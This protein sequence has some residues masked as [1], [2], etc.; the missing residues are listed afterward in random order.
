MNS[1]TKMNQLKFGLK[2]CGLTPAL[3]FLTLGSACQ[4]KTTVTVTGSDR[5]TFVLAGSGNLSEVIISKPGEEQTPNPL[6]RENTLWRISAVNMPGQPVE[7]LHS[8]T[9]GVVPPGYRQQ[10]PDE[11]AP[12]QLQANKRYGFLFVTSDAPHAAGYFEIRDGRTTIQ[13]N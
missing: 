13:Q 4:R 8:L 1:S 12:T 3:I 9:Y 7:V 5:P 10:I 6:D 2:R 11:G